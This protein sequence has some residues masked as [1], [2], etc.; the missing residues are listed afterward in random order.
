MNKFLVQ[1]GTMA[2]VDIIDFYFILQSDWQ[3]FFLSLAS[4][5]F[6]QFEADFPHQFPNKHNIQVFFELSI[7][8]VDSMVYN[9]NRLTTT[10]GNEAITLN[11]EPTDHLIHWGQVTY[12]CLGKLP[13]IGSDNGLSP[14]WQHYAFIWTNAGIFLI[15]PLRTNFSEILIAIEIFSF[16]KMYLKM[17]RPQ[18]VNTMRHQQT[19]QPS[20]QSTLKNIPTIKGV[21][22]DNLDLE[23]GLSPKEHQTT[24]HYWAPH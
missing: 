19:W 24:Y 8:A 6:T 22:I 1:I 21:S 18:C 17:S 20:I 3:A 23:N 14:G 16:K 12:I 13:I 4:L 11:V 15:G 7:S 2:S 10:Q 5:W 9:H